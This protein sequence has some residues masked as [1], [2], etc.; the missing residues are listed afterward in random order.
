MKFLLIT[1]L[2]FALINHCTIKKPKEIKISESLI[3]YKSSRYKLFIGQP[4]DS[5]EKVLH[6]QHDYLIDDGLINNNVLHII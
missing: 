5:I 6:L 1:L 2:Q 3:D 4:Q